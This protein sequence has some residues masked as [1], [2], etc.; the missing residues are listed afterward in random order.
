M[1]FH[2][3][4]V[5]LVPLVAI[6]SFSANAG[7]VK[8]KIGPKVTHFNYREP[9]HMKNM[10]ILYGA[11]AEMDAKLIEGKLRFFPS[12]DV[13]TGK[14]KYDGKLQ[15]GTPHKSNTDRY[16][17]LEL[18]LPVGYNIIDAPETT[19]TAF[20]GLGY[21]YLYNDDKKDAHA[22]PR[23]IQHVYAPIGLAYHVG[24]GEKTALELRGEYDYF[25]RGKVKSEVSKL[26]PSDSDLLHTQKKGGGARFQATLGKE[27]NNTTLFASA[28]YQL[29]KIKESDHVVNNQGESWEPKNTTHMV[30]LTLGAT[31]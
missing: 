18:R 4:F 15:S 13:V 2:K 30:G 22:Y 10:G 25:I 27:L 1:S 29:W 6:A 7:E 19:L 21:R 5:F 9:G 11:Q 20:T 12:F 8:F 3:L 28:N 14:T 16:T 24:L 23:T 26:D 31:L 17:I